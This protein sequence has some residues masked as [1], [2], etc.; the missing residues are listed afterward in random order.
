[1]KESIFIK[2]NKDKWILF[3]EKFSKNDLNPNNTNKL[4]TE[5]TDDLAYSRTFYR[6]RSVR[7]Y[8]N[9]AAQL[10][11]RKLYNSRKR[12]PG[13]FRKFWQIELPAVMYQVR[14]DMLI[15]FLVFLISFLVGVISSYKNTE[16][17]RQILGDS[18]VEMTIENINKG[19]PMAVYKAYHQTDMFLGITINNIKVAFFVFVLGVFFGV[20]TLMF[21]SYNGIMLGAFQYFFIER[22]LFI[23]SFLTIWQHGTPEIS[24]IIIAGG[25]GLTMGRGLIS[26]GTFARSHA[27]RVSAQRGIIVM[28]GI[29]PVFIFAGFI[30]AFI[31]RHTDVS[32]IFRAIT[33]IILFSGILAY[34]FW[35]PRF[36]VKRYPAANDFVLNPKAPTVFNFSR[37]YSANELFGFV[38]GFFKQH[39]SR[40]LVLVTLYVFIYSLFFVGFFGEDLSL[41]ISKNSNW[42]TLFDYSKSHVFVLNTLILAILSGLVFY[43]VISI[44][45]IKIVTRN[46]LSFLLRN[47]LNLLIFSAISVSVFFINHWIS[48]VLFFVSFPILIFISF[49]ACREGTN[50]F[51]AISQFFVITEKARI[52]LFILY[53]RF[54]LL[55]VIFFIWIRYFFGEFYDALLGYFIVLRP[56]T[57]MYVYFFS[58]IVLSVFMISIWIVLV[59]CGSAFLYYSMKE[60]SGA[61]S[62]KSRIESIG[63]TKKRYFEKV[64]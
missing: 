40:I 63:A 61:D 47:A 56:G 8:L 45:N 62:L 59:A 64:N 38:F 3:E 39:F 18:Y 17:V 20:G 4:F 58:E 10:L 41:L 7:Y 16:F 15:S 48:A 55:A 30:E 6:N 60:L 1:M 11:Y 46:F 24:A 33:I 44:E 29:V 25:A 34:F 57:E 42:F 54:L 52:Q 5:I 36:I 12:D 50:F 43:M 21:L 19:D 14:R 37:Y 27:F 31:T 22:D 2:Q 53:F 51:V 9:G 26:P 49:I 32:E 23:D 13:A 28:I 35:Y